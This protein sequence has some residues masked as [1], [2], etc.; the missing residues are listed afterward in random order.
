MLFIS[1]SNIFDSDLKEFFKDIAFE[2][3]KNIDY[4]LLSKQIL[5]LSKNMFSFLDKYCDLYNFCINLFY[6]KINLDDF[7]LQQVEFLKDL[8][9]GFEVYKKIKKPNEKL[10]YNAENLYLLLLGNLNK[11]ANDIFLNKPTDKHN[12]ETYSQGKILF[13]LRGKSFLKSV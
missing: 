4:Q 10:N 1:Y 13:D 3:E 5:I 2:E 11:T 12:K 9:N 7:K 8:M 6:N